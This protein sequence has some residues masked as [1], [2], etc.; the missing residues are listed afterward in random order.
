MANPST[1]LTG[2]PSILT[3][4]SVA[5]PPDPPY[6]DSSVLVLSSRPTDATYPSLLYLD[7]RLSLPL[8]Q[9]STINLAFAGLK[10]TLQLDPHL[11][12]RWDRAIDSTDSDGVD[13]GDWEYLTDPDTGEEIE[14]ET[15][16]GTHPR[17]GE[18]SEYQEVWSEEAVPSGSSYAF[19]TSS[20]DPETSQAFIAVLGP[21]AVALSHEDGLPFQVVRMYRS[22]A[23]AA[24]SLVHKSQ[25]PKSQPPPSPS[26]ALGTYLSTFLA[27]FTERE[28]TGGMWKRGD[29]VK[30]GGRAWTVFDAE[31]QE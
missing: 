27:L 25:T 26:H 29:S 15:G 28:G 2:S 3:R 7:L 1:P 20:A 30:L 22:S 5:W 13:E 10:R 21:H 11:R 4:T 17:T 16:V 6:E 31:I 9:K 14:V 19:L 12:Y 24:W 8:S 18:I 23:D